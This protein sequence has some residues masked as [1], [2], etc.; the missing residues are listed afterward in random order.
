MGSIVYVGL[1]TGSLIANV[2]YRK[3]TAKIIILFSIFSFIFSM[4]TFLYVI[5]YHV[6]L[7]S[8][9]LSGFFQVST[10]N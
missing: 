6:L 1:I 4:G 9:L 7:V 8:R 5:D 10:I 2:I 3:F